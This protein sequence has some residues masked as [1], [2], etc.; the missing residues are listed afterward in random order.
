MKL[1]FRNA[2][3]TLR[4]DVMLAKV[5]T[6]AP[7]IYA[8]VHQAYSK[9]PYLSFGE[10]T[11]LSSEGVQQGDPLGPFL[12]AL[13]AVDI[14]QECH[15]ELNCWYLDDATI[16]GPPEAVLAAYEKIL[17]SKSTHGLEINPAKTELYLVNPVNLV[18]VK[19]VFETFNLV[20]PGIN[21]VNKE[22]LTMLGAAIFCENYTIVP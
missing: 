16:G 9:E 22:V 20:T 7:H 14:T 15:T 2:F 21:L 17:E 8:F 5:R 10:D 1:D 12:F 19:E 6:Y 13:G 3:N 11:I 18:P 4:R